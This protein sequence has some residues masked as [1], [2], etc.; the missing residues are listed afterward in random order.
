MAENHKR[1]CLAIVIGAC[2]GVAA[3]V[4]AGI[5][6]NYYGQ[7]TIPTNYI[8]G[9]DFVPPRVMELERAAMALRVAHLFVDHGTGFL[10]APMLV[11]LLVAFLWSRYPSMMAYPVKM[12]NRRWILMLD[13]CLF[14]ALTVCFVGFMMGSCGVVYVANSP[15]P[16]G[17]IGCGLAYAAH[18]CFWSF[19]TAAVP[20]Y[21]VA[22]SLIQEGL[23]WRSSKKTGCL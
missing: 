1:Y 5:F 23:I 21:A 9:L 14:G 8:E 20:F 2:I 19:V 4:I 18:L 12:T 11:C 16:P 15:Y 10:V 22:I 13:N 17:S 7:W 3:L 6:G